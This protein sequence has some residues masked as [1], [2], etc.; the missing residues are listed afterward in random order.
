MNEFKDVPFQSKKKVDVNNFSSQIAVLSNTGVNI[1]SFPRLA[2]EV[3]DDARFIRAHDSLANGGNLFIPNNI[4]IVNSLTFT[5]TIHIIG[6]YGTI[7]L[8]DG[9]TASDFILSLKGHYS[10]VEGIWFDGNKVNTTNNTGRAEGLRLEGDYCVVRSCWSKDTINGGF[11]HTFVNFGKHNTFDKCVSFNAG[12]AA[13]SNNGGD[14]LTVQNC[15]ALNF[16]I[17]GFRHNGNAS[18]VVLDNCYFESN[19]SEVASDGILFDSGEGSMLSIARVSKCTVK[20]TIGSNSLKC[21]YVEKVI[22]E[23]CDLLASGATI[24]GINLQ[25]AVKEASITNVK[26]N[27]YL[28]TVGDTDRLTLKNVTIVTDSTKTE[29]MSFGGRDLIVD[30]LYL[31]GAQNGIRFE[32][33]HAS[34]KQ[35]LVI[36]NVELTASSASGK[37]LRPITFLGSDHVT[38]KRYK[39]LNGDTALF[40][41]LTGASANDRQIQR[42]PRTFSANAMPTTGTFVAGDKVVNYAPS[43]LGTAGSQY[44][45]D[46]WKRL[47]T[48]STNVL[49]TDWVEQRISTGS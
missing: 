19:T 16:R 43:V 12:Y 44:I 26:L 21:E 46:G 23:N 3:T 5:K 6:S 40:S 39:I 27:G 18:L 38:L 9:A 22:I 2:P 15:T 37:L 20:G 32:V 1:E 25:V 17:K 45:L 29:N 42:A 30:G 28:R 7:K 48:G 35:S 13:F 33:L 47:T 24:Y 41:G 36:D 11:A 14:Y 10:S 31:S 49:N 4:Y 34:G 8:K